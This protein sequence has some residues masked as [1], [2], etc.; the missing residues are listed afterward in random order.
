MKISCQEAILPGQTFAEKVANAERYGFDA[1]EVQGRWL[2]DPAERAER[3]R[4]LQDSP[5]TV[6]SICGGV[7]AHLID[8]DPAQRRTTVES[9]HRYFSYAAEL[10]AVGVINVPIF[11]QDNHMPDLQPYLSRWNLCLEL[12]VAMLQSVAADAEA[13]GVLYLLEPLNRYEA[14]F[15]NRLDQALTIVGRV[16]HR[17]GI[18]ILADF[19][20]MHIEETN[21]ASAITAAG[22]H[23]AHVHLADNTRKEPGSGETDFVP[24]F[25]ALH[26][27]GFS[28]YMALECGLSG[29]AATVLP[30]SVRYLRTCIARA[31][32]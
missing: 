12:T 3:R 29:P 20:H 30:E 25:A 16:A 19:F 11:A 27:A 21:I 14:N 6:S 32:E 4:I 10:G 22:S 31:T 18:G 28:G 23:V 1:I 26:R 15:L 5:V 24:G 2:E 8:V 17:G 7:P 13:Q 9:L